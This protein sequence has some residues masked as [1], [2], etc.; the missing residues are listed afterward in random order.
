MRGW[1]FPLLAALLLAAPARAE[2]FAEG[3]R[4]LHAL[5]LTKGIEVSRNF[6]HLSRPGS[7]LLLYWG[8]HEQGDEQ[9]VGINEEEAHKAVALAQAPPAARLRWCNFHVHRKEAVLRLQ[10]ERNELPPHGN[11][12]FPPSGADVQLSL[13]GK[14]AWAENGITGESA[15]GVLD[16][17][18][19]WMFR[20]LAGPDDPNRLALYRPHGFQ[21]SEVEAVRKAG[22]DA[23]ER[24]RYEYMKR[25]NSRPRAAAE[26]RKL[27]EYRHLVLQY[28]VLE[29][30]EIRFHP[31]EDA[32]RLEPCRGF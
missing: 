12:S 3:I 28:A 20:E 7:P 4:S 30:V 14:E 21:G 15:L 8:A 2:T 23:A 6:F 17:L 25:A 22:G 5:T 10:R 1:P 32:V 18:G 26:I 9:N 24:G 13:V 31:L 27:P 16:S 11:L 29:D 19:L